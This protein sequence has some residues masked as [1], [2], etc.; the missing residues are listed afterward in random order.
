MLTTFIPLS[1]SPPLL[2]SLAHI[3]SHA[4]LGLIGSA[5]GPL[6]L[7]LASQRTSLVILPGVLIV[8]S[9][10]SVAGLFAVRS[11]KRQD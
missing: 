1:P 6:F 9:G 7:G 11:R 4:G 2:P 10:I 5:V 3:S 8:I